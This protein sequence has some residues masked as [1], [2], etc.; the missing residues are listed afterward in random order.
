VFYNIPVTIS[1]S[2]ITSILREG[3]KSL[4]AIP[5][6]RSIS[7]RR[8]LQPDGEYRY[9]LSINLASKSAV[10]VFQNHPAQQRFAN[11]N[12]WPM[13]TDHITLDLEEC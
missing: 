11:T 1:E 3:K 10:T 12:F 9:S 4:E 6:V 2:E 13:I 7:T 8:T 5:G